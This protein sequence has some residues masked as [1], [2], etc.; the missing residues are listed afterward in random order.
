MLRDRRGS[1]AVEMALVA[2]L[3]CFSC[4]ARSKWAIIFMTITWSSRLFE[5]ARAMRRGGVWRL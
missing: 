5:T 3:L 4:S 1:A 2:P